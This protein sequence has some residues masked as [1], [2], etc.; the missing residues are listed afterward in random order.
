MATRD[1]DCLELPA[2]AVLAAGFPLKLTNPDEIIAEEQVQGSTEQVA[3][4]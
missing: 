1:A 2:S 3:E 4:R